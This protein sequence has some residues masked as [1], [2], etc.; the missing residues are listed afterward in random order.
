MPFLSKDA[1]FR[2]FRLGLPCLL[3]FMD[4]TFAGPLTWPLRCAD[5][6]ERG[7]ITGIGFPDINNNNLAA[8]CGKP[9][10]KGHTGTDLPI[11]S[12]DIAKAHEVLA[13]ADGTVIFAHDGK[14]DHCPDPDNPDCSTDTE[15]P[16]H[17][18]YNQGVATCSV[19]GPWCRNGAR[20]QCYWCFTGGNY[21]VLRHVGV[22]G[23][24][25]TYYAHMKKGSV[26]VE[27]GENVKQ[28]DVL[29]LVASSGYSTGPHLHFEL[30]D[31]DYYKSGDPWPGPCGSNKRVDYWQTPAEK[32]RHDNDVSA[33]AR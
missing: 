1:T 32:I 3:F 16:Y 6:T 30:W 5:G 10:Y 20:G 27:S 18:G 13:A 2:L 14:Y 4:L 31:T 8:N 33:Q 24:F 29:G 17:P 22:P 15:R 21:V 9:G 11:R 19:L 25:A 23:V 26:T 12:E 7:C 28:G